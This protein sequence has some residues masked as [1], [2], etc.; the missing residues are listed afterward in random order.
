MNKKIL[1]GI[2]LFVLITLI[3]IPNV[4][5]IGISPGKTT[6]VL[7]P[8]KPLEKEVAFTLHNNEKK[9]LKA[10]IFT[11]G[12]LNQSVEVPG[13]I[14]TMSPQEETKL[15]SYKV[16][17]STGLVSEPGAHDIEIVALELPSEEEGLTFI[18]AR[19]AVISKLNVEVPFPGKYATID[20]DI[21]EGDIETPTRF[22]IKVNN[23]GQQPIVRAYANVEIFG[24]T[25]ELITSIKTQERDVPYAE[26]REVIA[27]WHNK[28]AKPGPYFAVITVFYDGKTA[29]IDRRFEVGSL[30]IDIED[31]NVKNFKL[32]GIA[33]FNIEVNNKWNQEIKEVYAQMIINSQTQENIAELESAHINIEPLSKATLNTFWDTEG[34]NE[35]VF[36]SKII[37]HYADKTTEKLLK[38]IV[39]LDDIKITLIGAT[40]EAIALEKGGVGRDSILV[41]LVLVLV[42]VNIGW[43]YYIRK[44]NILTKKEVKPKETK[45]PIE[46]S[47]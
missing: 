3:L 32:G 44:R 15:L 31:V 13:G 25:N 16:K 37:L 14:I 4:Q 6:L 36:D 9:N 26:R 27:S 18:G 10:I 30:T 41:I 2:V 5:A 19:A 47:L 38:A 35:G 7:E 24:P 22:I 46:K 45:P 33:K 17:I 39:T 28:N 34:I 21:E 40:A 11:R 23:K 8:G 43:F 1:I 20:A 29:K 42:G 12:E